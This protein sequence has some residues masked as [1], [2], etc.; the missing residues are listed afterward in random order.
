MSDSGIKARLQEAMKA[1][2]KA[3]DTVRLDTVRLL[4]AEIRNAEIEKRAPL[5]EAEIL[6]LLRRGIKR[7]EES[8]A[9]FRQ[10]NREDLVKRTEQEIAVISEFLPPPVTEDELVAIVQE[11][12]AAFPEKPAFSQVMKEVMRRV[13]GRAEGR[14]VSEVVRKILEAG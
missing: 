7:R 1:A 8:L 11:V 4:L 13:E 6:G 14:V 12:L 5:E 10:G 9:Y 2:L 3:R